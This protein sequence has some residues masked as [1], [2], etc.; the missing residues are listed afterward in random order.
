MTNNYLVCTNNVGIVENRHGNVTRGHHSKYCADYHSPVIT[1]PEKIVYNQLYD[2][3]LDY[4]YKLHTINLN[5]KTQIIVQWH[6]NESKQSVEINLK[7]KDHN[8]LN[9]EVQISTKFYN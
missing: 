3:K 6:N 4:Q 5:H 1:A 7:V 9:E 2:K 8:I